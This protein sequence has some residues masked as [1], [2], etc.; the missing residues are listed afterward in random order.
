MFENYFNKLLLQ[1][2]NHNIL[3]SYTQSKKKNVYYSI[4]VHLEKNMLK[5]G[6]WKTPNMC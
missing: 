2:F 3:K 4:N 1:H 6:I 5:T